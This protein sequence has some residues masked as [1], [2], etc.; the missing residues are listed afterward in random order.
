[1]LLWDCYL[2]VGEHFFGRFV[3]QRKHYLDGGNMAF[4]LPFGFCGVVTR[5]VCSSARHLREW[6]GFGMWHQ[7]VC[8]S[9]RKGHGFYLRLPYME[10]PVRVSSENPSLML[11]SASQLCNIS[12]SCVSVNLAW[13]VHTGH[14]VHYEAECLFLPKVAINTVPYRY[15]EVSSIN[16]ARR[17]NL[18][19]AAVSNA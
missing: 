18:I 6:T 3:Y 8:H 4:G 16:P 17:T 13:P 5:C 19:R 1:M 11:Y 7:P 12:R 15:D 10:Q 14:S 2:S 9:P